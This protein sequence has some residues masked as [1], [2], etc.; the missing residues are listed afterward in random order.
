MNRTIRSAALL[1][2]LMVV[3][4]VAA[5][6]GG[7]GKK[8]GGTER[9]KAEVDALVD[10]QGKAKPDWFDD[11]PLNFPKTLDLSWPEPAPGPWNAQ[12][13]LGQYIWEVIN[14]NPNR[15][16]EG[17][18]LI[19]HVLAVNKGNREVQLRA[20]NQL[21]RMYFDL[22]KD[23]PRAAFWWRKA[24][25]EDGERFWS[26]VQLAECYFRMGNKAMA[27][28]LLG[29]LQPQFSMIKLLGDM[30]ETE[31]AIRFAEANAEGDAADIA[32][33]YAG[34]ACRVA[35]RHKQ[36]MQYYQRVL[37]LQAA[38]RAQRRIERNQARA[39]AN[40]EGMQLFDQ[41]DLS[42]VPD[43]TYRAS[44]LGYEDQVHVEVTVKDGRITD[45]RVTSHREKQFYS[46]MI[47]TPRK[48]IE[49]Q[50]VTEIDATSSA[51]ITSEAIINGTAKA[52][53]GAMK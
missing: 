4:A 5:A 13:N 31:Q 28:K 33:L 29:N 25:V 35:G 3:F 11:T 40:L 38:G 34:D 46:S 41:L 48:I 15:W 32:C 2:G 20:M 23:H 22:L 39:R 7:E 14:P 21:G 6:R 1:A 30:G 36:A 24:G 47:D 45:V 9:T 50:G 8:S 26:G 17:I 53:S 16:K 18:R 52:L 12:R 49:R 19:H 44:S 42:R 51:T 10:E 43:G 37:K 27:M